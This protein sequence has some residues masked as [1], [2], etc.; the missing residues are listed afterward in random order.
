MRFHAVLGQSGLPGL[1]GHLASG[2]FTLL[3]LRDYSKDVMFH[4]TKRQHTEWTGDVEPRLSTSFI[5]Y[6]TG[7]RKRYEWD[8]YDHCGSF[9]MDSTEPLAKL[10]LFQETGRSRHVV[11]VDPLQFGGLLYLMN[12]AHAT[13]VD[14]RG[15]ERDGLHH[16][17]VQAET[18]TLPTQQGGCSEL[19]CRFF[20][21]GHVPAGTELCWDYHA[22]QGS[23]GKGENMPC[24]CG[25]GRM[26][27]A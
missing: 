23:K 14:E 17:V 1:Q 12:Q 19:Q 6:Y 13:A 27:W 25:C 21:T 20:S 9:D 11:V 7:S 26:F 18:C 15:Q 2:I 10:A 16:P 8:D 5:G 22:G 3:A 24:A 4:S